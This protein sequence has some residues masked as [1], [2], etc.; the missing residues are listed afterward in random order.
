MGATILKKK[1]IDRKKSE[2]RREKLKKARIFGWEYQQ[3]ITKIRQG[4]LYL[5]RRQLGMPKA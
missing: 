5:N 4:Q 2:V 1:L 3:D